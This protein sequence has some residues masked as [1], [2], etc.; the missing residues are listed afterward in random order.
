MEL[1]GWD[2]LYQELAKKISDNIETINW[3]DLW[4]NQVGFL[5]EEHPFPTPAV[6]LSFRILSVEDLSEKAQEVSLQI[7]MFY[8]YETLLDTYQGAY[9][10]DDALDYLGNL[11]KLYQL[12][13]ATSGDNFSEMRRVGLA[14]VDTGS[15]GNLYRQSFTCTT[16]DATALKRFDIVAPGEL[17]YTKGEAPPVTPEQSYKPT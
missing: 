16:V 2:K 6:F 12:F 14:A 8:F 11:T 15:S 17:N 3:I 13:H 7:D 4:H 5:V 10:E 1:K 9:N